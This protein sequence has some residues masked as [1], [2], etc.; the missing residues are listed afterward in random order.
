MEWRIATRQIIVRGAGGGV[1]GIE[2]DE[3]PFTTGHAICGNEFVRACRT[4]E[5]S[6][7]W[8]NDGALLR[9]PACDL[10]TAGY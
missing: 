7:R 5:D 2:G 9:L 1:S 6:R 8:E 4:G 3:D 10:V